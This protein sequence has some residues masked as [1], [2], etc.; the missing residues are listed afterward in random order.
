[1]YIYS[2]VLWWYLNMSKHGRLTP[3]M[4]RWSTMESLS[5]FQIAH[6]GLTFQH[7]WHG[8]KP[9]IR[10][11]TVWFTPK[12]R[13][14][15]CTYYSP[16]QRK[17][18]WWHLSWWTSTSVVS[19]L[20][21]PS[22]VWPEASTSGCRCWDSQ[23]WHWYGWQI[24]IVSHSSTFLNHTPRRSKMVKEDPICRNGLDG[25]QSSESATEKCDLY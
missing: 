14:F 3:K 18:C 7:S 23:F 20:Y 9:H 16:F 19:H 1:M 15:F 24:K 10:G 2:H 12:T 11:P 5:A 6:I 25:F 21:H 4:A 8:W 13:L 22:P 17:T